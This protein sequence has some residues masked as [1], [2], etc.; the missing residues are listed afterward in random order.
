MIY[1]ETPHRGAWVLE[2]E[3]RVDPRRFF[4][5]TYDAKE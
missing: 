2:L 5:R 3:E 1:T 4:A